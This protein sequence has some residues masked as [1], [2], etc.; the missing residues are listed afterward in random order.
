MKTLTTPIDA[1]LPNHIHELLK[2]CPRA[3]NGV[4]NWLIRAAVRLHRYFADQNDIA[5]LLQK[6]SGDC[7]RDVSETEISEAINISEQWL[8]QQKGKP[9]ELR[10]VPRWP[11][12]NDEQIAAITKAGPNLAGLEASSPVRWADGQ[13]HTDRKSVV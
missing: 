10:A 8:A 6:Y 4:H 1:L 5:D 2:S 7:G 3:G 9:I 12:R 13:P 11:A